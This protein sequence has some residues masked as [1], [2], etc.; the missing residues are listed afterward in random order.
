MGTP[1]DDQ[2]SLKLRLY[3]EDAAQRSPAG[4]GFRK[5]SNVFGGFL[6]LP[7]A[8]AVVCGERARW[9]AIQKLLK[10]YVSTV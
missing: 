7:G 9:G 10:S 6:H 1:S 2:P 5:P 4:A 8:N 3:K